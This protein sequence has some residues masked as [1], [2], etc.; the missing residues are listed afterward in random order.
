MFVQPPP[1]KEVV[2]LQATISDINTLGLCKIKFNQ[3]I[4]KARL[5]QKVAQEERARAL[6]LDTDPLLDLIMEPGPY[7]GSD[8]VDLSTLDFV[9]GFDDYND[10]DNEL[11]IQINYTDAVQIS[12]NMIKDNLVVHF[13]NPDVFYSLDYDRTFELEDRQVHDGVKKQI[14]NTQANKNYDKST[15]QAN[16]SMS[17]SFIF[18]WLLSF[19][20]AGAMKEIIGTILGL[21]IV[22][23]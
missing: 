5:I 6:G 15:E 11:S 20:F 14:Q 9:W 17:G 12:P 1:T 3:K 16:N 7:E 19:V 8:Q 10:A 22:L 21:Q 4:N 13:S 2:N 18:T 23:F